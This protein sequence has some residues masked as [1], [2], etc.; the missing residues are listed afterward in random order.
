[1]DDRELVDFSRI[2]IYDDV[3]WTPEQIEAAEFLSKMDWEGGLTG[4]L[5]YGGSSVFPEELQGLAERTDQALEHLRRA[6]ND[7]AAARGVRY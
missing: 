1:M 7:W 2:D 4:L 5:E 3:N 6:V